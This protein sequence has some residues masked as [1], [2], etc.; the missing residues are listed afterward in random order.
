MMLASDLITCN[1]KNTLYCSVHEQPLNAE[2]R[3][4]EPVR[5]WLT[6]PRWP[7]EFVIEPMLNGKWGLV[8]MESAR[9]RPNPVTVS[10]TSSFA[11]KLRNFQFATYLATS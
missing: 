1:N 9:V 7:E 11:K 4:K 5:P 3:G 6:K 2:S 8:A 10:S